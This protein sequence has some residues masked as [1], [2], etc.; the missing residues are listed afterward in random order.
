[1][2]IP[3]HPVLNFIAIYLPCLVGFLT[4]LA[5]VGLVSE[6]FIAWVIS[7]GAVNYGPLVFCYYAAFKSG[8]ADGAPVLRFEPPSPGRQFATIS[9]NKF[10]LAFTFGLCAAGMDTLVAFISNQTGVAEAGPYPPGRLA[11]L[12]GA[13]AVVAWL[14]LTESLKPPRKRTKKTV[15]QNPSVARVAER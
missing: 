15:S 1:M 9:R 12:A 13:Y 2:R 14:A 3:Y 10:Y 5:V 6:P 4:S 8:R 7:S 11:V